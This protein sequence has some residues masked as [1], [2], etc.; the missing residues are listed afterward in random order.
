MNLTSAAQNFILDRQARGLRPATIDT[1]ERQLRF[2]LTFAH[3]V[4]AADLTDID[5]HLLR[6]FLA[7]ELQRGLAPASVRTSARTLRAFLNWTVEEELAAASPMAR[8]KMPKLDAP[9]PDAF[10]VIEV[11]TLLDAATCQRDRALVLFLLDTG[12]RLG[13][14]AVL[15]V[16]DIDMAT[17]RVFL[18]R[19]TKSRRPR[20]VFLGQ[21]ARAEMAAYMAEIPSGSGPLW[22]QTFHEGQVLTVQ[23]VKEVIKRLGR[24]SGVQPCGPHKFRRTHARWSL[25]AGM[26]IEYLR[27]L[28]GHTNDSLL[29]YYVSLD[30]D[31]LLAAHQVHGPV[32][33]WLTER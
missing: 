17:G 33:H 8:V 5:V 14:T 31:D 9:N 30:D 29:Q 12:A 28:M 10:T 7:T 16:G 25:R 21:I 11:R 2:F 23:G 26:E 22:W 32:D 15:T 24:R 13:E 20:T 27:R 19:H 4:G 18:R 1:Y 3:D 6:R